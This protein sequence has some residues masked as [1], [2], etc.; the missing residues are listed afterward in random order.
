MSPVATV[1][2]DGAIEA[3]RNATD[4]LFYRHGV[5]GVS[6]A[7]VRDAAGLS[8]RRIYSLCPSKTD[9]IALWL[10]HRHETWSAMLRAD[11]E[12]NLADGRNPVDAVFDAVRGWM[13]ATEFRG[14]GFINTHAELQALDPEPAET[15][16]TIIRDHKR[17]TADYLDGVTGHGPAIGVLVDGA[18]V[19]ASMFREPGPIEQARRAATALVGS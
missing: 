16:A 14:C 11:V 2:D 12:A 9:L 4:D 7:D 10:R 18:I 6:V 19:Q 13:V 17:A 3:L 1:D 8:L 5:A 15:I